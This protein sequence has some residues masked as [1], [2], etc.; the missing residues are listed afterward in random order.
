MLQGLQTFFSS[1]FLLRS[2]L[3]TFTGVFN[4]LQS[5]RHQTIKVS[6]GPAHWQLMVMMWQTYKNQLSI[7]TTKTEK[8]IV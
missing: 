3:G 5:A 8:L 7:R 6:T 1:A 2:F 4:L